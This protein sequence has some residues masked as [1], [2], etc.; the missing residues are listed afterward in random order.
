[1]KEMINDSGCSARLRWG[2]KIQSIALLGATLLGLVS[3][4]PAYGA[5]VYRLVVV[6]STGAPLHLY[7]APW[8]DNPS[9]SSCIDA[10]TLGRH[11]RIPVGQS[12]TL[13]FNR[14][15]LL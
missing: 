2:N 8:D 9:Q 10:D 6:N 14:S 12:T 15:G 7:T 1:M 3:A 13:V 11:L 4:S 5:F